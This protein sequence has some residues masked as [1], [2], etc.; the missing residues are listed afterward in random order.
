MPAS[1]NTLHTRPYYVNLTFAAPSARVRHM[2]TGTLPGTLHTPP[3]LQGDIIALAALG[4]SKRQ[5]ARELGVHRSAVTNV[6]ARYGQNVPKNTNKVQSL[7]PIAYDALEKGLRSG[8]AKLGLDFLKCTDLAETKGNT[9][10]INADNVLMSG[11]DM[12][13]LKSMPS[14][15][16]ATGTE[17]G[18]NPTPNDIGLSSRTNFSPNLAD[19]ST[20]DLLAE[21]ARRGVK[22]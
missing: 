16:P 12:M 1:G 9:Y 5:I 22:P 2:A 21:L 8:D 14:L 18:A 17:A 3:S 10:T 20:E 6:L 13:P 7:V 19:T 15:A 11:I 4:K